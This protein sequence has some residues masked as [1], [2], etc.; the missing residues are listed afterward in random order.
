M[1]G[2]RS[3]RGR[4]VWVAGVTLLTSSILIIA[5]AQHG[6]SGDALMDIANGRFI[7][8]HGY[9]PLRNV[10]TQAMYGHTWSNTEWLFGVL[11]A[12][13]YQHFGVQGMVWGFAPVLVATGFL[14]SL[15]AQRAGRLWG[16]VLA[17]MTAFAMVPGMSPRP[18]LFSYLFFA[19]GLWAVLRH[20][21]GV[22]WPVIVFVM[23]VVPLWANLHASVFLA[24]VLLAS[25]AFIGR[26]K[27]LWWPALA[28]LAL[29]FAHPGGLSSSGGFLSS[30]FSPGVSNYL[31][32][33][34][35]PDLF[36]LVGA[37]FAP[38]FLLALFYTVRAAARR[39]D[40][41]GSM[42][43]LAW[44]VAAAFSQRFSIYLALTVLAVTAPLVPLRLRRIE[45]KTGRLAASL[46]VA[47]PLALGALFLPLSLSVPMA[48]T[49]PVGAFRYLREHHATDVLPA[50]AFGDALDLYGP[51][52]FLDGRAELWV[53]AGWW[54]S[55]VA[56]NV[57]DGSPVAFTA[58]WDPSTQYIVWPL[59][60]PGAVYLLHAKDW[61][62]VDVDK[63]PIGT[64]G[65]FR[66]VG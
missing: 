21:K 52:P 5:L 26:R 43:T 65:V 62:L 13:L 57:G 27:G 35:S 6:F 38:V 24:P 61:R 14:I 37:L 44:L 48:V 40:E 1:A 25:E 66:K 30:I 41:V 56:A 49:E 36:T 18:Q 42:W 19:F 33:W 58:H 39:G 53:H 4:A 32:E 54:T 8:A 23:A 63:S 45:R 7:L 50:Y 28:A 64:V 34:Q 55:Y 11:A 17:V 22:R 59:H 29:S 46:L 10:M 15:L 20:R 16:L 47:A 2:V 60:Y 31:Q 9:V 3:R 51:R 12:L